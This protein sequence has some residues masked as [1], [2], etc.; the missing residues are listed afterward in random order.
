MELYWVQYQIRL[1]IEFGQSPNSVVWMTI[2]F[3]SR[4]L[5]RGTGRAEKEKDCR[6]GNHRKEEN[7][8]PT[9]SHREEEKGPSATGHGEEGKGMPA[10][11]HGEEEKGHQPCGKGQR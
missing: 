6:I 7:G 5:E 1:G 9:F 2:K 8:S 11:G 10:A 3:V 4:I